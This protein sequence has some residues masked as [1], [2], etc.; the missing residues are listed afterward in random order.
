MARWQLPNNDKNQKRTHFWPRLF[1][2]VLVSRFPAIWLAPSRTK[3]SIAHMH[4]ACVT[5]HY[6]YKVRG[7]RSLNAFSVVFR[8]SNSIYRRK[9]AVVLILELIWLHLSVYAD[10]NIGLA[11][12]A[13]IVF[14]FVLASFAEKVEI[15]CI[16]P[17]V[18]HISDIRARCFSDRRHK[19]APIDNNNIYRK[20]INV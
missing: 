12:I 6:A 10:T 7:I 5:K 14:S 20:P 17:A 15:V 2:T 8:I 19:M 1:R 9:L 18:C 11:K 3:V 4:T 16:L 13:E